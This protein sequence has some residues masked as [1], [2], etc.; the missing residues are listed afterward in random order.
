M[1]KLWNIIPLLAVPKAA[2]LL[3]AETGLHVAVAEYGTE[4][5]F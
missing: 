3:V 1:I 5:L 2:S 4:G